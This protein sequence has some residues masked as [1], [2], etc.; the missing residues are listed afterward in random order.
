MSSTTNP[1]PPV[2]PFPQQAPFTA[3][4]KR[5]GWEATVHFVLDKSNNYRAY[6]SDYSVSGT[7]TLQDI[8]RISTKVH[9]DFTKWVSEVRLIQWAQENAMYFTRWRQQADGTLEV[10]A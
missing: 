6:V 5:Y 3:Q 4:Y 8:S 2:P 1:L 10:I 9:A 7:P